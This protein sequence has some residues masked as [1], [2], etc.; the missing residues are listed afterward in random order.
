MSSATRRQLLFVRGIK[1]IRFSFSNLIESDFQMSILIEVCLCCKQY[2]PAYC[3]CI[4]AVVVSGK[5]GT[6]YTWL[7]TSV[8]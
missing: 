7:T 3:A 1:L 6:R 2:I 5:V 8:G 4:T